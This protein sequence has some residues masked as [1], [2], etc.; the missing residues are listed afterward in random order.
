MKGKTIHMSVQQAFLA[1]GKPA[2]NVHDSTA[3]RFATMYTDRSGRVGAAMSTCSDVIGDI[4]SN[5]TQHIVS[6]GEWSME[7]VIAHVVDQCG[8]M[9]LMMATWSVSDA[10]VN[11]LAQVMADGL[12]TE[13]RALLDWRVKVRRPNALTVLRVSLSSADLR[14]DN[15]HA[16]V[17]LLDNDDWHITVVGSPNLTTN[18]RM[19]ASV[20]TESRE[21][22]EFHKS[23]IEPAID[24]ANPFDAPRPKKRRKR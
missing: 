2:K 10:A 11:R 15:C 6:M 8:P 20:L 21:V 22:W 17:Y 16:K 1:L 13:C 18:P 7:H 14:L 5:E 4:H 3:G 19:E 24:G 23:W 9:R 12:I